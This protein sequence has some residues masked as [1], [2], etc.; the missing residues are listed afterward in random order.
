MV[1]EFAAGGQLEF[2][3]G[4]H[5]RISGCDIAGR[6]A[7]HNPRPRGSTVIKIHCPAL[8]RQRA[9]L[10]ATQSAGGNPRIT[11]RGDNAVIG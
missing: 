2:F 1:F 4:R 6:G 7:D 9:I 11:L 8:R 3:A 5:H 10:R